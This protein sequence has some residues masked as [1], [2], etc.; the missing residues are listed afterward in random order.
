[1]ACISVLLTLLAAQA[2]AA[3]VRTAV[4]PNQ[5]ELGGACD[6]HRFSSLWTD[7]HGLHV[8]FPSD[9]RSTMAQKFTM[10]DLD[11]LDPTGL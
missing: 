7:L 3:A 9:Q 10:N 6:V 4:R 5:Q 8:P 1:V 2:L 11:V